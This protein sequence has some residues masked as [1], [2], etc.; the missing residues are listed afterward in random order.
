MIYVTSDTHFN[1]DR[2]FI[3]GPRGFRNV[4]EANGA[5]IHNWNTVVKPDDD[6]YML[7][8]F[9]LGEDFDLIT[10]TLERL[11]GRIHFIR[12]NHDTDAKINLYL[13]TPNIVSVKDAEY[14]NYNDRKFYLSHYPTF[15][16]NLSEHPSL[17]VFNLHGHTHSNRLF[18]Q[19]RPYMYNV[20]VD[21]HNNTPVS[22]DKIM[23][24]IDNEIEV[25]KSFLF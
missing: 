13:E 24:D 1:H 9:F 21:A 3:Y 22:L 12:G 2:E 23:Q 5:L 11:N 10:G 6:I 20:A 16:S 17:A 14:L 7:G 4:H 25:C 15:T 18:S 19:D 8:D